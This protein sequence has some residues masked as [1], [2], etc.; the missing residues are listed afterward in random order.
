MNPVEE[1]RV[2]L[3]LSR[4]E[5][6]RLSDDG[7]PSS[8]FTESTPPDSAVAVAKRLSRQWGEYVRHV[9]RELDR[10]FRVP[11]AIIDG[12]PCISTIQVGRAL[13]VGE[14]H[15]S[16]LRDRQALASHRVGRRTVYSR[17]A[18]EALIDKPLVPPSRHSPLS[19]A[20][21]RHVAERAYAAPRD[22]DDS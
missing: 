6:L 15:L 20:F 11:F 9:R 8:I 14:F 21:L 22:G 5:F 4:P 10:E 18:I 7:W 17:A 2:R 1:V 12:E 19:A 3:G 16:N 13:G